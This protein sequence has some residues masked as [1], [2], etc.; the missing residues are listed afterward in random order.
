MPMTSLTWLARAVGLIITEIGIFRRY[1]AENWPLLSPSHGFV[2]LGAMMIT[3]GVSI[4]GNLNKEATSQKSLGTPMWRCVI[5]AGIINSIFGIVN[6][7]ASYIFRQKHLG[8]SARQVRAY[9]AE[10]PQ[11][12]SPYLPTPAMSANTT[13]KSG[14][15]SFHLRRSKTLDENL[16]SYHTRQ[17]S[18]HSARSGGSRNFTAPAAANGLGMG[19][20]GEKPM[21][22]EEAAGGREGGVHCPPV[23]E[24]VQ[25]PDLAHHPAYANVGHPRP[26]VPSSVYT[27]FP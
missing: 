2:T 14:R 21:T 7:F 1:I 9:G 10:A 22:H 27:T 15:R 17:Q 4:L 3:L 11:R 25:R 19:Y 12:A 24:G 8:I 6:I 23:V 16:P 18:M 20:Y 13:G 5:S 26:P